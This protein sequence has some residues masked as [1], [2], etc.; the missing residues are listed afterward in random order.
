MGTHDWVRLR[1]RSGPAGVKNKS[2]FP[3]HFMSTRKQEPSPGELI[4][5]GDSG[6][7]G[8]GTRVP[9]LKRRITPPPI[10]LGVGLA[11]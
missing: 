11:G 7:R 8:L 6:T 9:G 1:G 4:H 3:L 2:E 10:G 5:E